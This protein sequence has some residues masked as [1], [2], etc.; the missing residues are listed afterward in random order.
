MAT[1]SFSLSLSL[2]LVYDSTH[3]T[4]IP[5]LGFKEMRRV[6]FS[7]V[8]PAS[9]A[10]CTSIDRR[11]MVRAS[12]RRAIDR[13]TPHLRDPRRAKS[14]LSSVTR[15]TTEKKSHSQRRKS[16]DKPTNLISPPGSSRYL[17][18]DDA[19]F[20]V[21]PI[22]DAAPPPLFSVERSQLEVMKKDV[23]AAVTTPS[24]A[25]PQ[26]QVV[27]LRVSL[28][29]KGCEGKV[30]KHISKMEGD[31]GRRRDPVGSPEQ[32]IQGQEC[33]ALAFAFISAAASAS[34]LLIQ[35]CISQAPATLV[36]GTVPC[37]DR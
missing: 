15:T 32:H 28:H 8:S 6:N 5:L 11:S 12:T 37:S 23:P 10:I 22:V 29:C 36:Y 19:F 25:M 2:S 14:A 35:I 24:S 26:I 7:C 13:H 4:L 30:R 17:L 34:L 16:L 3:S 1:F 9:A 31:G 20:D 33:S 18:N 27:H 21:F